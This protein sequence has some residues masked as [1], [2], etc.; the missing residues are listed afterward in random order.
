[1]SGLAP[2]VELRAGDS[3]DGRYTILAPISSGAMGAVY[4]ARGPDGREVAVKRL[5][6]LR[7]AARFDIEAR[8]LSRLRHPRVVAVLEHFQNESGKYL[9][10]DLV[11]GEDLG[12]ILA[13]RGDPG[14]PVP[15]AVSHGRHVCEALR[16]VHEQ[17]I[18]HRDV[19]PQNLI[20]S[21][22]GTVLVD[23]GI[24]REL[25]EPGA[26][27]RAIG[28]PLYMA[29]EVLVGEAV[30]PRSDVYSLAATVWALITGRPPTYHEG[31]SLREIAPGVSPELEQT[32]R[33]ALE[34]RAERRI[35]SV[36]AMAAALGSRLGASD[37][38]SLARSITSSDGER[39]LLE[40]IVRTAAGVF[41]AAAASIALRDAATGEIVYHAAWGAGAEEIVGV[42]LQAGVGIAGAAVAGGESIAVPNCRQDERFAA[43]VAAGT[44]YVPHTMMVIPLIH[45][46]TVKGVLSILDR[47]DGRPYGPAD[48][49]RAEL[50]A[51]LTVTALPAAAAVRR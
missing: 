46:A 17:G 14:L 4:R 41:D 25:T 28:T 23:F 37:G 34:P 27:T 47:R 24:A 22:H 20:L 12:E 32:L 3:V 42:R 35:A 15:E 1:V 36:D 18:V 6:D 10:M 7:Q 21:G 26:G 29:P 13:H 16:Y 44:G 30:S 9:V 48:L 5:L 33:H 50:F 19:K 8:L 51:E 2:S 43:E 49:P 45:R 31:R 38:I 11:T 40:S 39:S